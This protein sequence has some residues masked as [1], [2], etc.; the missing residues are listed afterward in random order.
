MDPNAM[1]ELLSDPNTRPFVH[2]LCYLIAAHGCL[3]SND[4]QMY[5]EDA[6][7]TAK[8]MMKNLDEINGVKISTD[9]AGG[10]LD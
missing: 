3:S 9:A 1:K 6:P 10:R 7:A 8:V 2:S 5:I 4:S